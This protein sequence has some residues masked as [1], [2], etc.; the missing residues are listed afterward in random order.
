M[1]LVL[2]DRVREQ[3][4]TTGSSTLTLTGAVVGYQA[5]SAAI[6]NG[7][8]TYYAISNPGTTEWEV[9][10]G[11]V[12]AGTL[13]RTTI[14]ASSNGG[15]AVNFTAGSKDVFCT[16]PAEKS[17]NE[18]AAGVVTL[19]SSVLTTTDINGGTIDDTVIG[20]ASPA[21]GTFTT[22]T[23]TTGN[24]TTVNATT[25]NTTNLDLTNLEVTNIKAK[26]G[27]ASA[28]IADSTG[29]MTV[30]SSVLTTTDINGGTIDGTAVGASSAST[31]AFTTISAT[32]AITSTVTTGTAPLVIASTTKVSNLNVDLLDGADWAAPGAIGTGTP[33]TGAFTTISASNVITST[34]STG[35]APLVIASTTKVNNLNVDLLD[36]GDWTAPGT[37]G[38][39]T[40]NTG[41]F[42]TLAASGNVT[43]SGTGATKLQASTTANR[44]GT[45][46]QGMLRYNTTLAQFEGYNG[47]DWGGIGGAQAGGAIQVNNTTASV[48]YTIATGTN[49]FSVGPI[50]TASG[51]TIT[52]SAGQRWVVI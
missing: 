50:T 44:P 43:F 47:T 25:V 18:D 21:A 9:G 4:T 6:G 22:A 2:K 14:L 48:S 5:F 49:G 45:P 36:G 15:A 34:V 46:A 52:V 19:A 38:S 32:G 12:G 8:T 23:A 26:D 30:A 41:A 40:P 1:A 29:V 11:T 20:G 37:I 13:A 51:V 35:T 24:I 27:T 28:T 31:G 17:V 10:I 42:T 16:Y 33:N 39:G 7:N 3:S